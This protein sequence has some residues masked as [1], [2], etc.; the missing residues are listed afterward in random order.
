MFER[1]PE[2]W[3]EEGKG[4]EGTQRK[5]EGEIWM[6]TEREKVVTVIGLGCRR[7]R[8]GCVEGNGRMMKWRGEIL[9]GVTGKNRCRF[10]YSFFVES[11]RKWS[12]FV[13]GNK[14]M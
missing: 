2:E 1:R 14:R 4:M 11:E 5:R 6:W 10:I 8:S 7:K 9:M 12:S 13:K 3:G